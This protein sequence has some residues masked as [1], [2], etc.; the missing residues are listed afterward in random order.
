M[1]HII[2][3]LLIFSS[4][5]K[6]Q[7]I[8]GFS[9]QLE[10][11]KQTNPSIVTDA[12]CNLISAST[13]QRQAFHRATQALEDNNIYNK[14]F[15][16]NVYKF[17]SNGRCPNLIIP[18]LYNGAFADSITSGSV[19]TNSSGIVVGNGD[20]LSTYWI[21]DLAK[22]APYCGFG[23]YVGSSVE[24]QILSS[25]SPFRVFPRD[26]GTTAYTNIWNNSPGVVVPAPPSGFNYAQRLNIDTVQTWQGTTKY[27]VLS[28]VS[29]SAPLNNY[30]QIIGNNSTDFTL[31][32][33]FLVEALTDSEV[34]VFKQILD[35]LASDL[36][37]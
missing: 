4:S 6:A 15:A 19:T 33:S 21:N 26:G 16:I 5:C 25:T 23:W 30:C 18:L 2:I 20:T 34:L 10:L 27:S 9:S 22:N 29:A 7:F 35:N 12:Y 13:S 3:I 24:K 8:S 11:S 37:L 14:F 32:I 36:G 28:T 1:K 31:K 17:F